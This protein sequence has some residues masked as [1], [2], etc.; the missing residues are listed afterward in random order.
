MFINEFDS[1]DRMLNVA[2]VEHNMRYGRSAVI[3]SDRLFY[4]INV[5][6]ELEI[7][8]LDNEHEPAL[9]KGFL[10]L[11]ELKPPHEILGENLDAK[12]TMSKIIAKIY[13]TGEEKNDV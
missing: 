1:L 13:S 7:R 9:I 10:D 12:E 5:K 6:D 2:G 8:L 4:I 11:Q 3:N